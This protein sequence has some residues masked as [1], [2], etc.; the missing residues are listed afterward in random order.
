MPIKKALTGYILKMNQTFKTWRTQMGFYI[1][2]SLAYPTYPNSNWEHL[3][4][5][6]NNAPWE[7]GHMV[8]IKCNRRKRLHRTNQ[9]SNFL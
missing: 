8:D 4:K 6:D 9:A 2:V 3:P 7:E 1:P 5:N